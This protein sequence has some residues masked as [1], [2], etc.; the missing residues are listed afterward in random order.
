VQY[1]KLAILI[2]DELSLLQYHNIT[3][4]YHNMNFWRSNNIS[5][6]D[7]DSDNDST[8]CSDDETC[9]RMCFFSRHCHDDGDD[10]TIVLSTMRALETSVYKR[11]RAQSMPENFRGLWRR[12]I[13]EWM[14]V[15]V[16]YCKLKHEATAAA[17][18][19]LDAAVM[20][21]SSSLVKS[22]RDYQLCAVTALHLALKVYDSP[23][24]RVVK[25]SCFVKLGNGEFTEDDIIQKEQDLVR[26]LGWRINPPTIDCFLHRYME[27]L[28]FLDDDDD[29][30]ECEHDI[31]L[32]D[33]SDENSSRDEEDNDQLGPF[34]RR[35]R[36]RLLRL[37]E[38]ASE[39]IEVAMARDRF[40]SIPPSVIAYAALL[41]AMELTNNYNHHQQE[42]HCYYDWSTFLRNMTNIAEMGD[43]FSDT[44]EGCFNTH[45]NSKYDGVNVSRSVR[46]TKML[47]DRIVKGLT[48]PSEE[49]DTAFFDTGLKKKTRFS[50]MNRDGKNNENNGKGKF[51]ECT[52]SSAM[53][54]SPPPSPT[55]T[56]S[57]N[58]TSQS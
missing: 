45:D 29:D 35:R 33:D 47:L 16:K 48:L 51:A 52:K 37:E 55:S 15:L 38:V 5:D 18:Y 14:Y 22:P 27:L 24:V 31:E 20:C 54:S 30:N 2:E 11:P 8:S 28:P 34:E 21:D 10:R 42:E 19:Y 26:A 58:T 57:S 41:S 53:I 49:E 3:I 7:S 43:I 44:D 23:M 1:S 17:V 36:N 40:L 12:Q 4:Q 46:R 6:S 50:G 39:F 56:M 13:V 25:L 32:S 9:N